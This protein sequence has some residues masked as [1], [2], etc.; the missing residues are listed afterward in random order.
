MNDRFP[1]RGGHD[2]PSD[3]DAFA[4]VGGGDDGDDLDLT[5]DRRHSCGDDGGA[6]HKSSHC[7]VG[8]VV[9]SVDGDNCDNISRFEG[10]DD[11][12]DDDDSVCSDGS[13]D[14]DDVPEIIELRRALEYLVTVRDIENAYNSDNNQWQKPSTHSTSRLNNFPANGEG[15][16]HE[17]LYLVPNLV[18]R[19]LMEHYSSNN[20]LLLHGSQQSKP[21]VTRKQKEKMNQL[22][23]AVIVEFS[24]PYFA[25]VVRH[26][27]QLQK[28]QLL[29]QQQ[30]NGDKRKR[31]RKNR[32]SPP[33]STSL[34]TQFDERAV[35]WATACINQLIQPP[36]ST[37]LS[38]I[39]IDNV[40][41]NNN[42]N[43][44]ETT[45]HRIENYYIPELD[46]LLAATGPH[47]GLEAEE[48]MQ[49]ALMHSLQGRRLL[50]SIGMI[51]GNECTNY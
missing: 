50:Q 11:V 13:N 51:G 42:Q 3:S 9:V 1:Q 39:R 12:D 32:D 47:D 18:N 46:A 22:M 38:S 45:R 31:S 4:G 29:F 7:T 2:L 26:R 30:N 37:L 10:S 15:R 34:I 40:K 5:S 6:A 43:Q 20:Y 28:E 21:I 27:R 24:E 19:I 17:L 8:Q 16:H 23:L 49:N 41:Y 48:R 35:S 33:Q 14:H 44:T 25:R 36:T